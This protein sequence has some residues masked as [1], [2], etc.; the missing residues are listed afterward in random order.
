MAQSSDL[1]IVVAG[2]VTIIGGFWAIARIMLSQA[3]KEREADRSERQELSK[4]IVCMADAS[5]EVAA[6]TAKSAIEAELRNGHLA[7]L[8]KES[9]KETRDIK[10]TLKTVEKRKR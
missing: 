6:A 4:A 2:L 7:K 8:V 3:S 1:G 5:K 10:K 9:I